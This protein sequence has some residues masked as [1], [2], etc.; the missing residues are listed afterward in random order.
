[1]WWIVYEGE[2]N[3]W[4]IGYIAWGLM[5]WLYRVPRPHVGTQCAIYSNSLNWQFKQ[6]E[7]S[8]FRACL[9]GSLGLA[10]KVYDF[11]LV[12]QCNAR[13]PFGWRPVPEKPRTGRSPG[14]QP[15]KVQAALQ[16]A[17]GETLSIRVQSKHTLTYLQTEHLLFK[18]FISHHNIVVALAHEVRGRR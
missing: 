11:C 16:Q 12:R 7:N 4:N 17:T 8:T 14:L 9:V 6:Q 18:L 10:W 3:W 13:H 1:M 5:G 2:Y 15:N